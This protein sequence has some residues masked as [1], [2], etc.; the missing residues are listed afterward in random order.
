MDP[1]QTMTQLAQFTTLQQTTQLA[2]TQGLATG[3]SFLG[4]QVTVNAGQGQPSVTGTVTGIDS[5]GVASGLPP[6]LVLND[7]T[8]EYPL[9]S[10]TLVQ[11]PTP[12]SSTTGTSTPAG[13]SSSGQ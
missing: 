6:Q 9:T 4:S 13:T 12:V 2:Q 5:S 10:V 3:N 8:Q 7:T 11:Y 1:T